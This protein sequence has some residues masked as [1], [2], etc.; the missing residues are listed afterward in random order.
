MIGCGTQKFN[1][2]GVNNGEVGLSVRFDLFAMDTFDEP[3]SGFSATGLQV[4][5]VRED[6]R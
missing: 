5:S 4:Q 1:P 3:V 2:A 6:A